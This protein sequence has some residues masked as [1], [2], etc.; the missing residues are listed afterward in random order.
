MGN[1]KVFKGRDQQAIWAQVDV[2]AIGEDTRNETRTQEWPKWSSAF[3]AVPKKS[4]HG[5]YDIF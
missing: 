2:E 1:S 5:S 4:N 3:S